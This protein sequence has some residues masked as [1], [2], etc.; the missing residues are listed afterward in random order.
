M[1]E[2]KK[3][4]ADSEVYNR[5]MTESK[6]ELTELQIELQNL[7]VKF[8]LR[9]LRLYQTGT[10]VPLK[11]T[12]ISYLVK[13]ELTSAIADLSAPIAIDAIIKQTKL[14]WEKAQGKPINP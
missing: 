5:K 3:G 8:G 10:N 2:D 4:L 9:A 7:M 12:E 11:S 13:Y 14:E 1:V 6:N